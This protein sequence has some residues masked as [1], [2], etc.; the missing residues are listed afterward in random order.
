MRLHPLRHALL[1][2]DETYKNAAGGD[3]K[4]LRAENRDT[5]IM[6][7]ISSGWTFTAHVITRYEDGTIEWD[8][9]SNGH[10]GEVEK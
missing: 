6:Q 1:L 4:C 7:N 10:F 2:E 3:Y 9:S 8:Y 5:Y